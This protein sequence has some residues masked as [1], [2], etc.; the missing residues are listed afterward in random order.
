MNLLL[1][2]YFEEKG[3]D[4]RNRKICDIWRLTNEEQEK[5][6]DY[7]QGIFTLN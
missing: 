1:A 5:L 4:N 7:I 6:N 2:D 3:V